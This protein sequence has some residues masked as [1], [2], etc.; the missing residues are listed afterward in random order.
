MIQFPAKLPFGYIFTGKSEK[1]EFLH[2]EQK[3]DSVEYSMEIPSNYSSVFPSSRARVNI[4]LFPCTP[5]PCPS[6]LVKF[7]EN[8]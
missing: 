2:H 1:N 4:S 5:L 7:V 6:L 3:P 8:I